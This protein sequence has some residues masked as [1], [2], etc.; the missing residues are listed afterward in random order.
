MSS[1]G[2]AFPVVVAGLVSGMFGA[3]GANAEA[4]APAETKTIAG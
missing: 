1:I 4:I 2:F 3:T